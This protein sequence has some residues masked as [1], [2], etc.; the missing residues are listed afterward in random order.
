M[1][2]RVGGPDAGDTVPADL[3]ARARIRGR[4]GRIRR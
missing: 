1:N 2:G 3:T 4:Q